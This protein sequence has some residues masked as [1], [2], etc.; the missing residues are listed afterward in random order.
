MSFNELLTRRETEEAALGELL[1]FNSSE[2]APLTVYNPTPVI[3]DGESFVWARVESQ[4]SETDS[5]IKL[6]KEN[7][8][9]QFDL[10]P[11]APEF[12]NMQDPFDC[13]VID[14]YHIFGGVLVYE[15]PEADCLGYRTVLHR[16][17]NYISELIGADGVVSE[18]FLMGPEKMKGIRLIEI[19]EN[20]IGVFTRPQGEFGGRGQIG[21]FEI[22]S[23]DQLQETITAHNIRRDPDTLLSGLFVGS[24]EG[25]EEWGGVNSLYLLPDGEIGVLGHIAGFGSERFIKED[26]TTQAR[27][28]YYPMSFIFD[29]VTRKSRN[30]QIVATTKDFPDVTPKK[31]D[32]GAI[33]YSGGLVNLNH[34]SV[35]LYVGIGDCKSGRK[36][37]KD[38]FGRTDP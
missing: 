19:E 16:Y 33:I 6:F 32:L 27:K 31:P 13:G 10:F 23:L 38:P 26:G 1:I 28:E 30:I 18:P 12:K 34:G 22:Q 35:R 20:R 14:G 24:G 5:V 29:P 11:G 37:I 36:I 21:Y 4:A 8:E 25:E 15:D 3:I 17:K 2:A 9:G 7:N